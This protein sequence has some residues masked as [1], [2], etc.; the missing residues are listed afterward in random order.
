[1]I[2]AYLSHPPIG[3]NQLLKGDA[4]FDQSPLPLG[5]ELAAETTIETERKPGL[6][7]ASRNH[8]FFRCQLLGVL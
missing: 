6:L 4:L 1:M 5:P 2:R 7:L 8:Y 3:S